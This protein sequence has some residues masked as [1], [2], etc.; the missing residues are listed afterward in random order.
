MFDIRRDITTGLYIASCHDN[1]IDMPSDRAGIVLQVKQDS[2]ALALELPLYVQARESDC[3]DMLRH[4]V[5]IASVPEPHIAVTPAVAAA[6]AKR[7]LAWR[8]TKYVAA[9]AAAAAATA[10]LLHFALSY[11]RGES[12]GESRGEASGSEQPVARGGA[13][14][15]AAGGAGAG[16]RA[17]P[18]V[19]Q[20]SSPPSVARP[21]ANP[22]SARVEPVVVPAPSVAG[23]SVA[24]P[25]LSVASL[26]SWFGTSKK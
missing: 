9:A 25:D 14:G 15:G 5:S 7:A 1:V 13:A 16:P 19:G 3:D 18:R 10:F 2:D 12:R 20:G 11:R 21:A 6:R 4:L 24:G 26:L 23:P 22:S 8:T 17:G